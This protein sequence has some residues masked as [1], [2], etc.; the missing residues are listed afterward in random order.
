[1]LR[2]CSRATATTHQLSLV[3]IITVSR[4]G[5]GATTIHIYG[6]DLHK[7]PEPI[8]SVRVCVCDDEHT[9]RVTPSSGELNSTETFSDRRVRR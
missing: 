7:Y 3:I 2:H 4:W 1:M 9:P 5:G 6:F 8:R